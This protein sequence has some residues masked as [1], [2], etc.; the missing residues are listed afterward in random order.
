MK[1]TDGGLHWEKISR[2][3]DGRGRQ[4]A[5]RE[6]SARRFRTRKQR[7]FGV[8]FSIAPSPKNADVIWAGS[9]TGLVHLTTDGG[10]TWTDVTPKG[11]GDWSK[12][13]MIE[14]SH[15]DPAVAYAAVDRHRSGRSGAIL[16]PHARLRKDRGSRSQL[17]SARHRF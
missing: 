12:I 6:D 15:F 13:S 2:R 8:V 11:V 1:T 16:V 17:E 14:A 5:G 7:G 4:S 3:P 9:D 10:K